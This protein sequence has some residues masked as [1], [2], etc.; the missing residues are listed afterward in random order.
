MG[1]K[2]ILQ[3]LTKTLVDYIF[4]VNSNKINIKK[5]KK[6]IN[7]SPRRLYDVLN[8]LEGLNFIYKTPNYIIIRNE[9]YNLDKKATDFEFKEERSISPIPIQEFNLNIFNYN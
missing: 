4:S 8:I 5:I 6:D 1:K 7:T 2:N 9:F 3:K